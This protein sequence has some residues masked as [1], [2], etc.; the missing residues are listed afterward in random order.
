MLYN[1][2][3]TYNVVTNLVGQHFSMTRIKF[4]ELA[5]LRVLSWLFCEEIPRITT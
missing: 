3:N 4:I 2:P 1:M 5:T